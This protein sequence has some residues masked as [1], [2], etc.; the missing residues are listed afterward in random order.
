MSN[1]EKPDLGP[2]REWLHELIFEADTRLGKA[3]D[4]A[5]M[6]AILLSVAAVMLESVPEIAEEYGPRLRLV[7]WVFTALF[8]WEYAARLYCVRRPLKYATS[9]FGVID[10]LAILPSFLSLFYT[11]TQSLLVI[12]VLR[13]LRIFRVFKMGRYLG[14][15]NILLSA[16]RASGRKI[17]VFL[18][19]VLTLVVV[20]GTAMHLVEGGDNGFRSIPAAVYWAIVTIT[21]VGYGDITP[22]TGA[23]KMIASTVM[24]LGYGILAVPTGIVTVELQAAAKKQRVSTQACRSCAKDGHD[25]DAAHCKFCGAEL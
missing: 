20:L 14:E 11:G 23:G 10:L 5:L 21:T 18:G 4:V 13:M 9:F 3:F 15:A 7:E 6:V 19:V 25:V 1:A 24:I 22:Q 17:L 2:F 8:A 16:V 12:R